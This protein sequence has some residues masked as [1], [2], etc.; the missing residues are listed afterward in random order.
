MLVNNP[1]SWRWTFYLLL[2]FV[3]SQTIVWP[4]PT[5]KSCVFA[6]W[7]V[8]G[9]S[10]RY[11]DSQIAFFL[12]YILLWKDIKIGQDFW[13]SGVETSSQ[14]NHTQ[15]WLKWCNWSLPLVPTGAAFR[16]LYKA[17][18]GHRRPRLYLWG[19]L[20]CL[21]DDEAAAIRCHFFQQKEGQS[22]CWYY[23]G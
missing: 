20:C 22:D 21:E 6:E 23:Q 11:S 15:V 9:D 1:A 10:V 3:I 17:V 8:V 13:F 12:V 2:S 18:V 4:S 7:Q 16:L 5:P 19:S 14:T